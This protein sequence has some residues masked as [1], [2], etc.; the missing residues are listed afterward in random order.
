[1]IDRERFLDSMDAV[2]AS[3]RKREKIG[4]LGEKT[5]H[6]VLKHYF[7]PDPGYHEVKIGSFFADVA[8]PKGIT[9]IQTRNL[10]AIRRKLD[11]FLISYKVTLVHPIAVNK[12]VCWLDP[13]SGEVVS[14]R[15]SPKKA[16]LYSALKELPAIAEFID[17][18]N[19]TVCLIL[20]DVE[21]Y[22]LLDGYGKDKKDKATK[23]E[24]IPTAL[25][26]IYYLHESRDLMMLLPPE[27]SDTFT[28]EQFEKA[29]K[30][31]RISAH[32]A[33][34]MFCNF[35]LVSRSGNEGRK[36][37]YKING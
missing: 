2:L 1:M 13:A 6:A 22:R 19:L 27:L 34:K 17:D 31:D 7:E 18:P 30:L 23:Y 29:V 24:K 12:T 3:Q 11:F 25:H 37:V 14:K 9:E 33:L 26:D 20:C 15:R 32:R 35:G 28:F 36:Y 5:L 21:E 10:Y 16:M 8:S 4:T